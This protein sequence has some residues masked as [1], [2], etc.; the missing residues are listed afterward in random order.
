[1]QTPGVWVLGT[2]KDEDRKRGMGIVIE[3]AN[4]GG[5]PRWIVPARKPWDYTLFGEAPAMAPAAQSIRLLFGQVK[6]TASG[7]EEWTINGRQFDPNDKPLALARGTRYRLI[8]D[9]QT[10]DAHPVHLHRINFELTNVY[11]VPT[12]GLIK[13]VVLIKPFQK[14]EADLIPTLEGLALFHCHQ[15]LHMEHG[16]KIMF[17]VI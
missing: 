15:Q 10:E 17:E 11:G 1:M 6:G 16:F 3:Y 7:F 5:K 9:N 14:I 12:G 8:F 13:D 2:P 4:Q